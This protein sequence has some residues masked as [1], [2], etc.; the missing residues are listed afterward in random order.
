M[1]STPPNYQRK[2]I[3]LILIFLVLRGITAS[4]ME[5]GN[6]ETYYWLFSQQLQ[7]NYFD[8]PGMIAA[9]I[10]FF[11]LNG[12]LDQYEVMVRAGSMIG[13]AFSTWFLYRAVSLIHDERAGWFAAC[14][15]NASLYAGLIAGVLVMPDSPQVFFWTFCLWQIARLLQNDRNWMTWLLVGA[16]AGL[17]IMSKVHGVFLWSGLGLFI[18]FKKREWLRRPQL[19]AALLL[20]L[21]ISSPIFFWNLEYDFM[22]WKFHSAR[23]DINQ[24]DTGKDGFWLELLQ[25]VVISNP[26]NFI[27]V[28]A[29]FFFSRKRRPLHPALVAYNFIALPLALLLIVISCFRDIW[30]HW[31]GPAYI[32]LLPLA[33]VHLAQT[34]TKTFFPGWLKWSTA[35][36]LLVLAAWPLAIACYPGTM[37]NKSGK[38]LGKGDVTLDKYGWEES[39]EQFAELYRKEVAQ[40]RLSGDAPV[41]C[42][43][44]WGAHVEYYF[45]R[46]ADAPVIGLGTVQSLHQYAWLNT[47]R[48]RT[49]D[50]DTAYC[51]VASIEDTV[52]G[53]LFGDYY[54]HQEL[55]ATIPVYRSGK[56]VSNFY[57]HRLTGW[58]GNEVNMAVMQ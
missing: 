13:C 58:K 4:V 12:W 7:W 23:V 19:Y 44:W 46:P 28:L 10:R 53:K 20:S 45:A 18:L 15:F 30:F 42:P 24:T 33:A 17:C 48:L 38:D 51:V 39:G 27:L 22:T 47:K 50:M 36:F 9:W 2:V 3:F 31:S 14:L 35:V 56:P 5:L 1:L 49:A 41:V 8:H 57:I 21:L 34:S 54:R 32:T 16:A 29:A 40:G 25:Q 52:T 37:G 55:V 11:T 43:T 6:D 26:V